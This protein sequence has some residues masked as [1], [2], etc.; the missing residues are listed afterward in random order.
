[1]AV[2]LVPIKPRLP[3]R[4][5]KALTPPV[6]WMAGY[7]S[8]VLSVTDAEMTTHM[9]VIGTTGTGKSLAPFPRLRVL[10]VSGDDRSILPWY[11][12]TEDD[13]VFWVNAYLPLDSS[14]IESFT[15]ADCDADSAEIVI[16]GK[17]SSGELLAA[18]RASFPL[19]TFRILER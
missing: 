4:N 13:W 12:L 18:C 11:E 9:M 14:C 7:S 19:L 10:V 1:M 15:L 6:H 2:Q 8:P 3:S 5:T 16:A 17:L